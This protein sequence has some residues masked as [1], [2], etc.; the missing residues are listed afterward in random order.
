MSR[1]APR[2]GFDRFI[3]LDWAAAAVRTRAGFCSMHD[4]DELLNQAVAGQAANQ[5]TRAVLNR[6]W[7]NP[8]PELAD[9]ASRGIDI[10]RKAPD[11]SI[12]ALTWGMALAAYP[13][14]GKVSEIVGRL[15]ALQGH[16]SLV[17]VHRRMAEVYGQTETIHRPARRILQSQKNWGALEKLSSKRQLIR[18]EPDVCDPLLSTW[19]AE[20][21]LR[22]AGR[23]LTVA[24][25]NLHPLTYPFQLENPL[26]YLLSGSPALDLYTD[27]SGN[28]VVSLAESPNA[29][30][31]GSAAP[32]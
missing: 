15:T 10:Y 29:S 8:G 32:G 27:S 28:Q 23:V 26:A 24:T 12:F 22:C 30:G 4:F 14:F 11:T 25:L 7:L 5:K 9:F 13:F 17:A 18:K 1:P 3:D 6:L 19:L 20:A 21:C 31:A 16:C 2:I